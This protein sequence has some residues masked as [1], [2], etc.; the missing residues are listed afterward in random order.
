MFLSF[1]VPIYNV[2]DYLREC[3]DSLLNQDIDDYEIILV[4]DGSTDG[5][6]E[7]CDKYAEK[8]N[9]IKAFH[10]SNDG[11]S[12]ARNEGVRKASGD[13]LAFVDGD[14]YIEHN[15]LNSIKHTIDS[16]NNPQIVFMQAYKVFP[17]G[18][19]EYLDEEY[20]LDRII[21][22]ERNDVQRYLA[23]V[24]KYPGSACTKIIK[25]TFVQENNLEFEVG[26]LCEDLKYVM[27]M[28]LTAHS[29]G[30][31]RGD[32]YYY[33]Q[34]REGSIS[35]SITF[36]N[37]SDRMR[38]IDS[39]R[40]TVY[41]STNTS[42]ILLLN[43]ASAYEY[44]IMLADYCCIDEEHRDIAYKWL[45]GHTSL[46]QYRNDRQTQ[47]IRATLNTF[48]IKNTANILNKYRSMRNR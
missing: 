29:F 40:E 36:K 39:W 45:C 33:R 44:K 6:S 14:D 3:I 41:K 20:D 48:G 17:D 7:I 9:K 5:S 42:E 10:K 2:K 15:C 35:N 4:D 1:I 8:S 26:R 23:N 27:D 16:Q 30:Y 25:K 19:R 28:L 38:I 47:Y 13:Y 37:Y 22:Q 32:Y 43:S 18:K 12:S 11:L 24:N 34:K 46:L 31:H 21:N